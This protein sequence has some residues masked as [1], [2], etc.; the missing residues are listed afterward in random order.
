[1]FLR[2]TAL[3]R[4]SLARA[5]SPSCRLRRARIK[6]MIETNDSGWNATLEVTPCCFS[7]PSSVRSPASA[8]TKDAK[9]ENAGS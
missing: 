2:F 3:R 4:E 7:L 8:A 1:M 6:D 9:V 5:I